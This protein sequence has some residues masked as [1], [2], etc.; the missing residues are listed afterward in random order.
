[1]Q[2][3]N[4]LISHL[5]QLARLELSEE[6]RSSLASDLNRILAMME[7]LKATNVEGVEPLVYLNTAPN[8]LRA[9][10]PGGQSS[11]VDALRNAP[12]SDGT[13]FLT[14]RVIDLKKPD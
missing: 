13:Y 8:P 5:E 11:R 9:D 14:P 1:M 4:A 3:D 6:E 7:R 12:E 2:I 10:V